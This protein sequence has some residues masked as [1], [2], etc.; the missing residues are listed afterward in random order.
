[1]GERCLASWQKHFPGW[2]VRRW[3]ESNSPTGHPFVAKMMAEGKFAFASDY[4]RLHA[5]A[6]HGG[7]YLDTDMELT[8]DIRPLLTR[9]CVLAF[10]SAQNR[11]SKNSAALGFLASVTAHP[12]ILD[13][14]ERYRGMQK[15]VMNT[16]LATE[17][18]QRHGRSRLRS[19]PSDS[20][21][22]DLGEIRI[23]HSD[24]FYPSSDRKP[25]HPQ[26]AVHHAEGSWAGQAAPL[27]WWRRL[28]DHRIDRKI[29]RPLERI[30]RS[31][32]T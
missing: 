26:L 1:M 27:P 5:L 21:F 30:L 23:Y 22:W 10:L 4:I 17:S 28:A 7:V 15:A 2:E 19:E 32:R 3:D 16:T 11:P 31:L 9:P 6:E 8:G 13:L 20:P 14:R 24:F 29:L 18:L 12:W 25:V